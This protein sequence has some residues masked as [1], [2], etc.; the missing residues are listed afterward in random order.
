MTNRKIKT[1][2]PLQDCPNLQNGQVG[3]C[4]IAGI[5]TVFSSSI[6]TDLLS[7]KCTFDALYMTE[8]KVD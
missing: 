7:N 5:S 8:K 1:A 2:L 6:L 3:P 4:S